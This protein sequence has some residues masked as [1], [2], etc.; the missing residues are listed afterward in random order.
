[1]TTEIIAKVKKQEVI[2]NKISIELSIATYKNNEPEKT[3][4][5][6]K[7]GKQEQKIST[8]DFGIISQTLTFLLDGD[9]IEIVELA[10]TNNKQ[11]IIVAKPKKQNEQQLKKI[12]EKI[13]HSVLN[14]PDELQLMEKKIEALKKEFE[15]KLRKIEQEKL[16]SKPANDTIYNQYANLSVK[17]LEKCISNGETLK[18][19]EMIDVF[20]KLEKNFGNALGVALSVGEMKVAKKLRENGAKPNKLDFQT[21]VWNSDVNKV[22]FLLEWG[23]DPNQRESTQGSPL[24]DALY[25]RNVE[26]IKIIMEAGGVIGQYG[27]TGEDYWEGKLKE[28]LPEAIN[29]TDKLKQKSQIENETKK[30]S[31][32]KKVEITKQF[33]DYLHQNIS[34]GYRKNWNNDGNYYSYGSLKQ[35][36]KTAWLQTLNLPE[37]FDLESYYKKLESDSIVLKASNI[38]NEGLLNNF[39]YN[40]K[41]R[42]LTIDSISPDPNNSSFNDLKINPS[43]FNN[44]FRTFELNN[45]KTHE[46]VTYEIGFLRVMKMVYFN[47]S[48]NWY[49]GYNLYFLQ[50]TFLEELNLINIPIYSLGQ[51]KTL[52]RLIIKKCT[53]YGDKEKHLYNFSSL[54]PQ[55]K[56]K[57]I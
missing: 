25:L 24:R 13:T 29:K 20:V 35:N 26:L 28:L 16:A 52:K 19:L 33:W 4:L 34:V 18:V 54:N 11:Q 51:Y 14:Q 7:H 53:F 57:V 17:E 39:L 46:S 6:I 43:H 10:D 37:I 22:R 55:C 42:V 56:L 40:F 32:A 5:L 49:Y 15:D 31:E 50:N 9:S 48:I 36:D 21:A 23:A 2:G 38:F 45:I 47:S 8:N 41:T 1:M 3:I 12:E 27:S 44:D 30:I